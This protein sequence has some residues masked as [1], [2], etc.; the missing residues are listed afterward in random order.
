MIGGE[1]VPGEEKS[2]VVEIEPGVLL[3]EAEIPNLAP[4]ANNLLAYQQGWSRNAYE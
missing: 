4:G 1:K 3:V 2:S